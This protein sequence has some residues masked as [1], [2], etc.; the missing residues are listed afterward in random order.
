[1]SDYL[2]MDHFR[3]PFDLVDDRPGHW[4]RHVTCGRA[5]D[6]STV[7]V[8]ERYSDCSRWKCPHCDGWCDDRPIGWGGSIEKV[9]RR[10]RL[11]QD[12]GVAP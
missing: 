8:L 9:T 2:G 12:R 3:E 4:V 5:H 11:P 10:G 6:A 1:V 7:E